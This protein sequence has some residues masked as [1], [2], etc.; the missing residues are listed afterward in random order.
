M[1]IALLGREPAEEAPG[2]LHR[3]PERLQALL[4]SDLRA[5]RGLQQP[6][7]F[8]QRFRRCG[9]NAIFGGERVRVH[10]SDSVSPPALAAYGP[11]A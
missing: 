5:L 2:A 7:G 6:P 8:Q 3:G 11:P 10:R 9:E 4:M 1:Q